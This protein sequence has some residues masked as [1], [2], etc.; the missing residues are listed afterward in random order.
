MIRNQACF[1]LLPHAGG[2]MHVQYTPTEE[3]NGCMAR[4]LSLQGCQLYFRFLFALQH[5]LSPLNLRNLWS[6]AAD[7]SIAMQRNSHGS[8]IS[9]RLY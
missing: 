7:C 5:R 4:E 1:L 6:Q 9:T 8:L 3:D 2:V